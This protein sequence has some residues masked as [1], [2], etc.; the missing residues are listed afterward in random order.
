MI[1]GKTILAAIALAA[2]GLVAVLALLEKNGERGTTEPLLLHCAAGLRLPVSAIVAAYEKE[3][4]RSV[5]LNFGPS[6]TLEATLEVAGGDLYLPADRSYID[7]A[8]GKGLIDE[9]IPAAYLTGGLA[10]KS[11]NPLQIDTLQDLTVAGMKIVLANPEAAVGKFTRKVLRS[12]GILDE[13]EKNVIVT[14]PTV[15]EVAETV[16]LGLADAGIIWDALARQYANVEFVHVP[17][18]DAQRKEATVGVLRSTKN[19]TAALQFA[20]FLTARDRGQKIF[21]DHG[22]EVPEGDPWATVPRITFFSGS[23]LRPAIEESLANFEKR[24]GVEISTVYEGCGTLVAQMKSGAKPDA[25]FSC[26]VKFLDMVQDRFEKGTVVARNDIVILVPKDGAENVQSLDDLTKPGIKLGIAHPEKSALG[27]LTVTLLKRTQKWDA[28]QSSGNIVLN[29]S[30]GD[31]LVNQVQVGALD[32][33]LVYRS[34]ALASKM[35][36]DTCELIEISDANAFATQPYAVS[37]RAGYPQMM[38]RLREAL[39][40]AQGK[41]SF[42]KFGFYWELD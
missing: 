32:A 23:M 26:D 22:Y 33:A 20:R 25:Y 38:N 5:Q 15:N 24:E 2:A 14:K 19:A 4:G 40:A 41:S 1:N 35:I 30:K 31:E 37:R 34:N 6:G 10:V 13:I 28:I 3:T 9:A 29:A 17:E 8:K 18:F 12:T 27:D 7:S 42:L 21:K 39:T 11:G 16:E 36:E